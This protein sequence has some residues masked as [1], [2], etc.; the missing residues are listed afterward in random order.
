[1]SL[2]AIARESGTFAMVAM[3]QR[4]SLRTMMGGDA[5]DERLVAFKV[6]VARAL[7]PHCSGF[8]MDRVFGFDAVAAGRP[9]GL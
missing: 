6:A 1:V 9:N 4:E 3:D 7:G 5:P 2:D 8:L